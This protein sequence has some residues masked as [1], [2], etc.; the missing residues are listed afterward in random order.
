MTTDFVLYL[1]DSVIGKP[2]PLG[3]EGLPTKDGEGHPIHY[4]RVKVA[5]CGDWT[6]RGTGESFDISRDR[7]DEWIRNTTALAASGHKPFVTPKHTFDDSGSSFAEPDARDTLGYVERLERQGDDVFA[8]LG[9][10]GDDALLTAARNSRSI[11]VAKQDARD[12]KGNKFPGEYLHHLALCPNSALPNLGG[13]SRIAASADRPAISVPVFTLAA[14]TPTQKES[15]MNKELA[16]KFREKLGVAADVADDKLADLAA[17]KALALSADVATLTTERDTLKTDRDAKAQQVLALSA[18][19]K[20]PDALSLSL[21][22][23]SFKTDR[24]RVVESGVVSEA[25]MKELD[26]LLIPG[27]KPGKFALAL[28]AG[29]PDPLYCRVCDILR[30]NPG[31]KVNNEIPRDVAARAEAEDAIRLSLSGDSSDPKKIDR[32]AELL[33]EQLGRQKKTA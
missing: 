18:N 33:A 32:Q 4:R 5:S 20:E 29:S 15:E 11:G 19:D 1:D 22:T 12:A 23:R 8:I 14:A 2:L 16:K 26:A 9:L 25:G 3:L 27:G 13:T 31:V 17:E 28:S 21:V 6:H 7:A 24:D 30:R 10:N